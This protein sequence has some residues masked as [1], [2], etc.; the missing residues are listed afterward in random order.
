MTSDLRGPLLGI[1]KRK[2]VIFGVAALVIVALVV[3]LL[4]IFFIG[5]NHPFT[6]AVITNGYGCSDI[7][8]SIFAKGGSVADAAI[9]TLFC[10]GVSMPQSMG[11]GG[12]F[13]LTIYKKETGEV[14]SLNARETAPLDA[15][16]TMF[17]GDSNLSQKGGLAVA[18]PGELKGYWYLHKKYG[19]LPWRTLVEPTI[20][21]CKNGIYVTKFLERTFKGKLDLLYRDPILRES[22]IDPDTNKTYREG[23]YVKRARL[24]KSLELIAAEGADAL[25]SRNGSLVEGFVK[26]V[27]ENGG[28]IKTDDLLQYEPVWQEPIQAPL[29][30]NHTLLTTPLP[31]SGVV[32]TFIL[33]IL[34][35]FLDLSDLFNIRDFQ[36]I[37]ETFK[38]AYGHRTLLGD[39]RFVDVAEE[40]R[41]LTSKAFAKEIRTK[42]SDTTTRQDVTYYGAEAEIV[43]DHGTAQISILAPNGDAISV[44]STINFVFGAGFASSSTGII[45]N[46]EMDDFSS[47]DITSG[48]NIPPS[49]SNFIAPGK[50]P[51]SSMVPSIILKDRDV[52]LVTGAAGGTKIT[53][54]VAS[55]IYKHLWFNINL[56]EATS[57]KRI[58]HQLFPMMIEYE[59]GFDLAYPEIVANLTAIGHKSKYTPTADGFS[60]VISVSAKDGIFAAYDERRGGY[61]SY[62]Q[63]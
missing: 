29:S 43:E 36:R 51:L 47:P 19:S 48:F 7:G 53:T 56:S 62:L 44:T 39:D 61:I 59:E 22:F 17:N 18:V 20:D 63:N 52:V 49:K 40:I 37:V 34:D 41:N 60:A 24:A 8:K 32:L 23:Q 50:R 9:A 35:G 2:M 28:I 54:V 26:D 38:F 16:E 42:I 6:G 58:H 31:G 12:G 14:M 45:M 25:Y 57:Q 5:K 15:N 1:S 55:L 33:N 27:Q 4:W 11:L 30:G 3:A 46:N 13:L 21:L 10:E